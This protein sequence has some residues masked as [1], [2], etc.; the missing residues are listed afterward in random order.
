MI[1]ELLRIKF[2]RT[3]GTPKSFFPIE[4]VR[5]LIELAETKTYIFHPTAKTITTTIDISEDIKFNEY[6]GIP[7][8]KE[9]A[10]GFPL[11]EKQLK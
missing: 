1:M 2:P 11:E 3:F 8:I 4:E 5:T 7:N 6:Y 9:K 10:V